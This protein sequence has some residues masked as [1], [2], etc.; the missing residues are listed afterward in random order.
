ME[1]AERLLSIQL[2]HTTV[3]IEEEIPFIVTDPNLRF[4]HFVTAHENVDHSNDLNVWQLGSAL[5][6]ELDLR[7]PQGVSPE[8][9][10]RIKQVR[11]EDSFSQWLQQAVASSVEQDL[12]STSSTTA[13][14]P[15][16]PF[17]GIFKLLTG[18]QIERAC[19]V[20]IQAGNYRL[21]TLLA[22]CDRSDL[23]FKS[24][25]LQQNFAWHESRADAYIDHDLRKIYELMSGNVTLSKGFGQK[26]LHADHTEDIKLAED[27]DWKR[28]LGIHFWFQAVRANF[29]DAVGTYEQA[30]MRDRSA[31]L[32]LPWY[33]EKQDRS[34][35]E[36]AVNNW[37][38]TSSEPI[39]DGMFHLIKMFVNP[40]YA[41]ETVLEPRGYGPS[42]FDHRMSWHL[43]ILLSRVMRVRDF[44][45]RD[46]VIGERDDDDEAVEGNSATAD[47]LTTQYATQ[48]SRL[49][50]HRWAVFVLL[51]LELPEW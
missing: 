48:L 51:H 44:E 37:Q 5:Y 27:L 14:N 24:D 41:L 31:T 32:P 22:Q 12:R 46:I 13:A 6:D 49:G 45:D 34:K 35:T 1:L 43:Y 9:T 38:A 20:S 18:K 40:T 7:L 2:R 21:A 39:Y 50:L 15:P 10:D 47:V 30:F 4:H 19:H 42:P 25:L 3:Q 29:W 17:S 11:R 28:N 23:S 16:R 26:D 8:V 33:L 36:A